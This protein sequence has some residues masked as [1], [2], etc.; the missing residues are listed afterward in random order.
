MV[1][2]EE[3]DE[4]FNP[5]KLIK[6]DTVKYVSKMKRLLIPFGKETK[7]MENGEYVVKPAPAVQFEESD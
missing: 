3:V 6:G 5:E 4:G 2:V 7:V 1:A